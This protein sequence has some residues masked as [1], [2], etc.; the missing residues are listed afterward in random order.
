MFFCLRKNLRTFPG[1]SGRRPSPHTNRCSWTGGRPTTRWTTSRCAGTPPPPL[2]DPL[3]RHVPCVPNCVVVGVAWVCVVRVDRR[4]SPRR[5]D[6]SPVGPAG[7]PARGAPDR[8]E[9]LAPHFG[10]Y[11]RDEPELYNDQYVPYSRYHTLGISLST[12][13]LNNILTRSLPASMC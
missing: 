8:T 4:S 6:A 9:A 7:V 2:L 3:C 11:D 1:S 10:G 12:H 5:S 13:T